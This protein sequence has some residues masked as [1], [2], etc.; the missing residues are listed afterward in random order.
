MLSLVIFSGM[1]RLFFLFFIGFSTAEATTFVD[2]CQGRQ[3]Q[4]L[5]LLEK[6]RLHL[7]GSQMT[8]GIYRIARGWGG[9]DK[10]IE[11][12]RKTPLGTY[13]LS[14]PRPS[15]SGFH[16]FIGFNFPTEHQRREGRTGSNIGVHGPHF[17][18]W[19]LGPLNTW[20]NWTNGCVAV[21][22]RGEI[23]EIAAWVHKRPNAVI[24][25]VR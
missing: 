4:V 10:F 6:R 19:W 8:E 3:D 5:V 24:E 9:I 15:I 7:C 22:T 25:L 12:D 23:E 13:R 16:L 21:G 14:I 1:C 20:I 2:P 11:G 18:F 17:L